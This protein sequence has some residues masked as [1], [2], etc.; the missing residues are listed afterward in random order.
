MSSPKIRL[1]VIPR[2]VLPG[3]AIILLLL[4]VILKVIPQA[5]PVSLYYGFPLREVAVVIDPSHGGIDPGA[6]YEEVLEKEVCLSVGLELKRLLEQA[7][8]RV[9]MTR[10][11]DRDVSEHYP[12]DLESRYQRDM[13]GR[14]RIINESGADL[15]V[16]LHI[17]SFPDPSVRGAIVFYRNN[18]PEN[19]LL[20]EIIQRNINPVVNVNPR[21]GQL[22]HQKTK[23]GDYLLTNRAVIPGVIVEMAFITNPDDR[24]LIR[25]ESHRRRLAGA[26]FLGIVEHIYT[27]RREPPPSGEP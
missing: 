9:I 18:R 24:A 10:T 4:A 17:N 2:G 6:H 25:Q 3:A 16:S 13:K 11:S 23:E 14:L 21:P 12:D 26:I 27:L 22:I 8:A 1:L 15:F 20:A 7:G 19:P 5:E